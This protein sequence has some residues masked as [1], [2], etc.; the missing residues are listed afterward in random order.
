MVI[1][2]LRVRIYGYEKQRLRCAQPLLLKI[3]RYTV[4][5]IRH[6]HTLAPMKWAQRAGVLR[7]LGHLAGIQ[8]AEPLGR[9]CGYEERSYLSSTGAHLSEPRKKVRNKEQRICDIDALLV[10]DRMILYLQ[11][12]YTKCRNIRW[13]GAKERFAAAHS[14][15]KQ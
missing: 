13:K 7:A 1:A 9:G 15:R 10:A 4:I 8:G 12:I 5:I 2:F 14:N 3:S 11:L 6:P